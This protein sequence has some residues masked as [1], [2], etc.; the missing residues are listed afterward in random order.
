MFILWCVYLELVTLY[1]LFTVTIFVAA[2]TAHG[3]FGL[4]WFQGFL[5]Q[6]ML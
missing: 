6:E 1:S 5:V 3:A 4:D 2:K